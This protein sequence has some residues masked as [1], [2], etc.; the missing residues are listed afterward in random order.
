MGGPGYQP[1]RELPPHA[2]MPGAPPYPAAQA[3]PRPRIGQPRSRGIWPVVVAAAV[4]AVLLNLVLELVVNGLVGVGLA[5]VPVVLVGIVA[6]ALVWAV[7]RGRRWPWLST[8]AVTVLVYFVLRALS[9]LV[10]QAGG[11][12]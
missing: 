4:F 10:F 2:P 3:P 6:G 5:V 9:T 12:S 11:P 8:V 1:Y 7:A